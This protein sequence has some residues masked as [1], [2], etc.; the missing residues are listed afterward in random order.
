MSDS[1][2][3]GKARIGS[4]QGLRFAF[5]LLVFSSHFAWGGSRPFDAGGDSAVVFFLV[6]A[7]FFAARSQGDAIVSG[8]F[9]F[10]KYMKRRLTA[11]YPA[12]LAALAVAYV[13][14]P[15]AFTD[16]RGVAASLLLVQSWF[17]DSG[18]FWQ[19]NAPAWFL[20]DIVLCYLLFWPIA[21]AA[22]KASR[23]GVIAATA[24]IAAIYVAACWPITDPATANKW[25]YVYPLP[26]V[27][28]FALGV[29]LYR[30][31]SGG[32]AFRRRAAL[33]QWG[34]I[35]LVVVA[36]WLYYVL[37]MPWPLAAVFWLPMSMLVAVFVMTADCRT[38]LQRVLS[39]RPMVALGNASLEIF[40]L[41]V[42]ILHGVERLS[43]HIPLGYASA[44]LISIATT[45]AAA[46][47][48][49]AALK[50]CRK[51]VILHKN[52]YE[53][54]VKLHIFGTCVRIFCQITIPMN[55][56]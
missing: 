33:L 55:C 47:L 7:G 10:P 46:L 8:R 26:R 6:A 28:D 4:I 12:H 38:V 5:A 30:I 50:K 27:L 11:I 18:Y 56:L 23:R 39:S 44:L 16:H 19:C 41:H 49:H 48:L 52:M 34:A 13:C 22:F 42:P 35:A 43:H 36:L 37:P 51:C 1:N 9:S 25:L 20:S 21:Y 53:K 15:Q 29:T 54:C 17:I 31:V 45:L 40:L 14:M 32:D 24:A 2:V 3:A